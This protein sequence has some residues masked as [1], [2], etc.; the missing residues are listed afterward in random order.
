[1]KENGE[2]IYKT[3]AGEVVQ[4][5]SVVSTRKGDRLFVHILSPNVTKLNFSVK[6]SI[7]TVTTFPDGKAVKFKAHHGQVEVEEL[8]IPKDCPDFI[9]EIK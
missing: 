5:D 8:E 4:G 7:H 2:A 3:S 1:M 9:L 6:S